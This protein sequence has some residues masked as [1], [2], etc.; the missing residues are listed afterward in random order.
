MF[1]RVGLNNWDEHYILYKELCSYV[2]LSV[3]IG[4]E[5]IIKI[6]QGGY[7]ELLDFE[8]DSESFKKCYDIWMHIAQLANQL[9]VNFLK[10][11]KISILQTPSYLFEEKYI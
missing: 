7:G 8:Y 6:I 4:G 10:R 5:E 11:F 9:A 2:H 3:S 1:T